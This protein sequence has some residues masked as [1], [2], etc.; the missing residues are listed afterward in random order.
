MQDLSVSAWLLSS[1]P[2]VLCIPLTFPEYWRCLLCNFLLCLGALYWILSIHE[3]ILL[4]ILKWKYTSQFPFLFQ[5]FMFAQFLQNQ[6]SHSTIPTFLLFSL[7]FLMCSHH[8]AS[9][10]ISI[11]LVENTL[12]LLLLDLSAVF[13]PVGSLFP[14]KNL[15]HM[16]PMHFSLAPCTSF[17][18]L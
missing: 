2:S 9:I 16:I 8:L 12:A 4:P 17:F 5:K 14:R 6:I 7:L 18:L 13:H 3:Q 15:R 11:N 1:F 10:P